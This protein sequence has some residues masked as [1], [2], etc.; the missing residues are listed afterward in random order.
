MLQILILHIPINIKIFNQKLYFLPNPENSI[1]S[2]HVPNVTPHGY[3]I[4]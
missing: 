2:A 1:M 4:A 3:S